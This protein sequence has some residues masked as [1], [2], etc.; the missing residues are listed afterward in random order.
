M[1]GRI[2]FNDAIL[3][4]KCYGQFIGTEIIGWREGATFLFLQKSEIIFSLFLHRSRIGSLR[5]L[6]FSNHVTRSAGIEMAGYF[7]A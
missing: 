2:I 4:F 7:V 3:L 5:N 1:Y 6:L